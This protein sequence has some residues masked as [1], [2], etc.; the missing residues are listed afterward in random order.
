MWVSHYSYVVGHRYLNKLHGI[1]MDI[2]KYV[3][4]IETKGR[5]PKLPNEQKSE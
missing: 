3:T 2:G 4:F 5:M 1:K